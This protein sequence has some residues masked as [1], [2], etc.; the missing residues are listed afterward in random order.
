MATARSA[1]WFGTVLVKVEN[2][3]EPMPT[4]TAST[5]TLMPEEMT[6]PSTRSARNAVLFHRANGTRTK[7]ASV[8]SLN[9]RTVMKSWMARM[10]KAM[11]TRNQATSSTNTV[12]ELEKIVREADQIARLGASNGWARLI[13]GF[14]DLAGLQEVGGAHAA[15]RSVSTPTRRRSCR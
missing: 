5:I 2:S 12:S 14:G 1:S 13:A 11:M 9:S 7:P 10:K 15:A 3:V 6:L 8:V 4:M